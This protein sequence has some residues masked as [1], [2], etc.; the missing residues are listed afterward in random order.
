METIPLILKM[1]IPTATIYLAFLI[2]DG[3]LTPKKRNRMSFDKGFAGVF[4]IVSPI[5]MYNYYWTDPNWWQWS[6]LIGM[7]CMWL[8]LMVFGKKFK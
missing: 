7:P 3:I 6:I 4:S 5:I 2:I 8:F 1:I